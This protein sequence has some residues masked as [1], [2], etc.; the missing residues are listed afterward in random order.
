[1]TNALFGMVA[2][3]LTTLAR[4]NKK[5]GDYM[6]EIAEI[7][8]YDY[9]G[10]LDTIIKALSDINS[11]LAIIITF[12]FIFCIIIVCRFAYRYFNKFFL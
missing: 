10:Q 8:M 4:H 7:E 5:R 9:T 3:G 11:I 6:K 1:M 12:L 2:R